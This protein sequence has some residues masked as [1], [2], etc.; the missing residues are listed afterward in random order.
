MHVCGCH[1]LLVGVGRT[2]YIFGGCLD[3]G[4]ISLEK[5]GRFVQVACLDRFCLEKHRVR[6]NYG[7]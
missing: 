7:S 3:M 2:G 4:S 6:F 5:V 1:W